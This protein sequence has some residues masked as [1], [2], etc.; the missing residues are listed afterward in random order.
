MMMM[1]YSPYPSGEKAPPPLLRWLFGISRTLW[2]NT[3]P[4]HSTRPGLPAP[5][6]PTNQSTASHALVAA[7]WLSPGEG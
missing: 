4:I 1:M 3:F 6:R 5:H 7:H 2:M